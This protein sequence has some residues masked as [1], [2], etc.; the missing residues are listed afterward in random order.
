VLHCYD[1]A[2]NFHLNHFCPFHQVYPLNF[3]YYISFGKLKNLYIFLG[4]LKILHWTYISLLE[5]QPRPTVLKPLDTRF[6]YQEIQSPSVNRRGYPVVYS[7]SGIAPFP[8][9]TLGYIMPNGIFLMVGGQQCSGNT[10]RFCIPS[11]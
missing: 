7:W 1:C 5:I 11:G 3:S 6:N 2:H 9:K 4:K 10:R 8:D